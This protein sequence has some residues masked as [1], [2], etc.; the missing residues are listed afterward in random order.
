[1]IALAEPIESGADDGFVEILGGISPRRL[2]QITRHMLTRK[3]V[4]RQIGV[5][6]PN[7]VIAITPSVRIDIVKFVPKGLCIAN[8]IQPVTGPT[9]SKTWRTQKMIDECF[10]GLR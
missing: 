1:M 9:F 10:V 6:G 8:Q 5:E 2:E 4:V 3:L 7:D